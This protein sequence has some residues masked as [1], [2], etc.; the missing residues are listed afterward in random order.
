VAYGRII[1]FSAR[2]SK[3]GD[4]RIEAWGERSEGPRIVGKAQR[5]LNPQF[6]ILDPIA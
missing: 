4:F 3:P 1:G 2:N 5:F 6:R